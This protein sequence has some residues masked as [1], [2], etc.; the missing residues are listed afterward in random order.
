MANLVIFKIYKLVKIAMLEKK[1]VRNSME[2]A[3]C[4]DTL[5]IVPSREIVDNVLIL[6]WDINQEQLGNYDM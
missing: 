1:L 2:N 4:N 5:T 6:V 3:N